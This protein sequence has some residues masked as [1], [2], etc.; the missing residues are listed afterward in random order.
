MER[1]NKIDLLKGIVKGKRSINEL[2]P[3]IHIVNSKGKNFMAGRQL[4]DKEL[5]EIK[6][7][8]IILNII[9]NGQEKQN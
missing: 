6:N 2:L 3:P 1:Q 5:A 7:P 4:T 8:K 9:Y